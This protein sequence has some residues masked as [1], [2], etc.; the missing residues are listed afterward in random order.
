MPGTDTRE[1]R[2]LG[3]RRCSFLV[4]LMEM[5]RN[6]RYPLRGSVTFVWEQTDGSRMHGDGYTRDISPAGVFVLTSN[7]LPPGTPVEMEV[8]LP[9]LNE[10]RVGAS[11]RAH[12]RVVRSEMTGFAAAADIRFRMSFPEGPSSESVGNR[13]GNGKFETSSKRNEALA[14][15]P[16]SRFWM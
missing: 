8:I 10:Q 7:R 4:R 12:A 16:V 6:R 11:L 5:R 9:S 3:E 15:V 14:R 2:D 1:I 13:D